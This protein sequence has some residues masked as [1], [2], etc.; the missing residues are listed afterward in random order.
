MSAGSRLRAAPSVPDELLVH[1]CQVCERW[2]GPERAP[3]PRTPDKA[4]LALVETPLGRVVA[5]R[6]VP[7]GWKR[8]LTGI[9][10]RSL[11]SARA[12][13]LADELGS[14]GL[15]TP[16]PLAVLVL[17]RGSTREAVLVTRY[18]E[19]RGP[20]EYLQQGGGLAR[21]L[22]A[23][24]RDLARLHGL[25]FRHRDLKASNLLLCERLP[26]DQRDQ[27]PRLEVVWTDLDGLRRPGLV[28]RATRVRDLARLS[29]SFESA[30]ARAAGVRADHW[31]ALLEAYLGHA[32]A[33][34]PSADELGLLLSSTRRW[35]ERSL[36]R[37]LRQGRP[38][39]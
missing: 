17:R 13:D 7:A 21:L 33:R 10:A 11:R 31:P 2:F 28:S 8:P 16:E 25:G 32:L 9:G 37:H 20:W 6:E 5:K 24:A 29:L 1:W 18:V 39:T 36:H 27:G 12:F 34:A 30:P 19:G 3:L 38:V 26:G 35:A 4:H 15:V 23:L 22:A 14:C